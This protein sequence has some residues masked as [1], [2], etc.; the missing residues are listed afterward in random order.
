[1]KNHEWGNAMPTTRPETILTLEDDPGIARLQRCRLERAGF[2]V[3]SAATAQSALELL[4]LAP[5]D[6]IVLDF[7]LPGVNGLEFYEQLRES[8]R[9]VAV[10]IVTGFSG[11][12]TIIR[13][14]RAGVRDF[15]T[16]SPEYLDYLPEAVER[17]LKQVATEREIR[18]LHEELEQRVADRT[19]QLEAANKELESFSYSVSHD[20]RSPLRAIDG[21]SR[22]VL[23]DYAASLPAEGKAFLRRICENTQR[24]AQLVDD[25]LAFSRLGRQA[26]A[27][28]AVDPAKIVRGCLR[29]L[30]KEQEGRQVEIVVG[31]LSP[32]QADPALLTQ[33][34]TNLL[35]NALKYTRAREAAR[36]EIGCRAQPRT[37]PGSQQTLP[38]DA[39]PEVVFYVKDNGAG[40]DMQYASK[41]FGVFQRLHR[42][43]EFEGTGV[44]LAIVERIVHRHGGRVWAEAQLNQGATFSFTLG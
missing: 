25:L 15:V 13:A 3:E 1:M 39:D 7:N 37:L 4:R 44:G 5:I 28:K 19:A 9:D 29:E 18:K 21:F 32:C 33:V 11:E 12:A 38:A 17:V 35:S 23:D 40:F 22:I 10:I 24:M 6:L 2:R 8:G 14:L 16:K 34:W 27:K 30:E 43:A 20:L 26:L 41:L 42:A 31:D 36:I